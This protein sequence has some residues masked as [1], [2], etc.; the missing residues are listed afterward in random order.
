MMC[1]VAL[2]IAPASAESTWNEVGV[3]I[4]YGDDRTTWIWIPF[5]EDDLSLIDALERSDLEMV[6]VGFG[7]MGEAVCQIDTTGCSA[8]D[9]RTRLCQTSSSSPFWRLMKQGDD[10]WS[11]V[12]SG[13]SGTKVA[14][15]D[16]YALSWS[17][18]TPQL[19]LISVDEIATKVCADRSANEPVPALVNEGDW[20][21]ESNSS[22]LPAIAALGLVVGIA[23]FLVVRARSSRERPAA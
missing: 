3:I 21:E 10:E 7:G 14:D 23:W 15:G 11:M 18:E 8:A 20:P 22:W 2:V 5:E 17:A 6:T 12:G 16:V 19:P 9:C 4:D 1:L 13:V